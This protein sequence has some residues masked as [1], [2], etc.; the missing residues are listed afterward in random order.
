M[1]ADWSTAA[2]LG[3]PFSPRALYK[4]VRTAPN[5]RCVQREERGQRKLII[6]LVSRRQLPYDPC[7]V[8]TYAPVP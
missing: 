2:K 4:S 6:F 8:E 3:L 1:V 5:W 7:D